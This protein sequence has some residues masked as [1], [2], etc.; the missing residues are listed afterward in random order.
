[1]SRVEERSV[2]MDLG[3]EVQEGLGMKDMWGKISPRQKYQKWPDEKNICR[4]QDTH[5]ESVYHVCAFY[6]TSHRGI[7]S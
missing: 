4:L 7:C 5:K 1:M 2:M 6:V 3:W